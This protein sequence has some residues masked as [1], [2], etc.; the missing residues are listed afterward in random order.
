[1]KYWSQ[2]RVKGKTA[3]LQISILHYPINNNDV[4]TIS[5]SNNS[6]FSPILQ[7]LKDT[8]LYMIFLLRIRVFGY[9]LRMIENSEYV[10]PQMLIW[11]RKDL[12]I[13]DN[14]IHFIS[15]CI[16]WPYQKWWCYF[17]VFCLQS[18][19]S[20]WKDDFLFFGHFTHLLSIREESVFRVLAFENDFFKYR[21]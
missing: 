6:K 17:R 9:F 5:F 16:K 1:M 21:L 10:I 8:N 14:L 18:Y 11:I 4:F 15:D 19:F 20:N 7:G 2:K 3:V 13:L 12:A